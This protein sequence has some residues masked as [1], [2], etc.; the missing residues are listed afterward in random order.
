MAP[1]NQLN[2]IME[3]VMICSVKAVARGLTIVQVCRWT[4]QN[5]AALWTF[6]SDA[7]L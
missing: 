7:K 4:L 2:L 3:F 6:Q 5:N 1:H